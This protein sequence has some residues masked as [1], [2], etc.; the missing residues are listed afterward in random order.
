M[1]SGERAVGRANDVVSALVGRGDVAGKLARMRGAR[2]EI[3][4][5]RPRII[6]VLFAQR[7]KIDAA[8][9]DARRRA[10]LQA[11]DPQRQ[12]AQTH[13]QACR[14]RIAGPS[15]GM[16]LQTHVNLAAQERADREY[17]GARAKLEA[18]LGDDTDHTIAFQNQ[19]RR[20]LLETASSASAIRACGESRACITADP[21]VRGWRAR[22]DPCSSSRCGTGCQP[23]R[24]RAP[25]R[26]RVRRFP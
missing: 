9:V 8:A 15:A 26:R 3:G 13:R 1:N 18:A 24:S 12:F 25:W 11:S 22:R 19:I 6:A 16:T 10:G 5:H 23:D 2:A 4:K 21:P 14:W 17:D 20:F 7:G